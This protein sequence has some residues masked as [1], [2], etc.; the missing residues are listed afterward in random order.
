MYLDTALVKDTAATDVTVTATATDRAKPKWSSTSNAPAYTSNTVVVTGDTTDDEGNSVDATNSGAVS[1]NG[2]VAALSGRYRVDVVPYIKKISTTVRTASGLKDSNIRSAS[3]KYSILANNTSNIITVNGFNFSTTALVAKIADTATSAGT[4]ITSAAGGGTGVTITAANTATATITNSSITKSGYLELFSNGVRT[5]NNINNNNS[6]GTAK[7]SSGVQ[8]AANNATVSDYENAYNREADYYTTK[9]VQLTDDR[10]LR[11]FDM[12]DTGI[13]NGYYPDMI[14][15]GNTPVMSYIDLNG[16]NSGFTF[17]SYSVNAKNYM[18]QRATFNSNT[19]KPSDI[20]HLIGGMTWD[21]MTMAKDSK[22]KYF[23]ASVVNDAAGYLHFVYDN[24]AEKTSWSTGGYFSTTYYDGW[25]N[26]SQWTSFGNAC[27][28]TNKSWAKNS[29]NNA[30][31]FEKMDYGTNG[32]LIGRYQG[33]RLIAKGD[34]TSSSGASVYMAY[35]DDNTTNK[36]II[37]RTFKVGTSQKLGAQNNI[38]TALNTGYYANVQ[39]G[40]TDG[41]NAVISSGSKYV[42][43]GVTS[44][45]IVIIVYYDNND[46]KLKLAYSNSAIDGITTEG[47]TFTIRDLNIGD[48]IGSYVSMVVDSQ[49]GIHISAF[50]GSDSDLSYIY[51]SSYTGSPVKISVDQAG[52]VGNWTQIKVLEKNSKIIPYIA[53]YNSTETGTRESIKLAFYNDGITSSKTAND[54]QGVDSTG[55]TTNNWEYMT[56]PALT[57]PQGGDVKCKQVCLDFDSNGLPVVGYLGT[58]LEFGKWLTE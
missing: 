3:G 27:S 4:G 1:A 8:L 51:L 7:N 39:D 41:R 53:Y 17:N 38:G 19:G 37:F 30:L 10:Y 42:D 50:D 23:H 43:I 2:S 54:I 24:Y 9:N 32:T 21:Q 33:L 58:N 45:N 35:Y 40:D 49:N 47:L 36:N 18:P 22:G 48:Y 52:S 57:P 25:S 55:Y 11:F 26:G 15:N 12:K 13:K 44:G 6:Y 14:M 28:D 31:Y 34:S 46:S 16:M 20:E 56:V 5:L 29:G